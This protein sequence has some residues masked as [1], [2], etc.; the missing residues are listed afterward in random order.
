M[1]TGDGF[2]AGKGALKDKTGGKEGGE[3]RQVEG[4]VSAKERVSSSASRAS[5]GGKL[6]A[7]FGKMKAAAHLNKQ[8]S[9][10]EEGKPAE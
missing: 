7:H 1:R 9:Q 8:F 3:Q 2:Q 10:V 6:I 4:R 5:E